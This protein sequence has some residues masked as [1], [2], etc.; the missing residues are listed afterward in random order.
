MWPDLQTT[1]TQWLKDM[2]EAVPGEAV[3]GEA[4]PGEAVPGEAALAHAPD[5][6]VTDVPGDVD[7]EEFF[8]PGAQREATR[9]VDDSVDTAV[10]AGP[11]IGDA[12]TV[13]AGGDATSTN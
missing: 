5:E 3:P 11:D 13:P 7:V 4:V 6:A 9:V 1:M 12:T 8:S 10:R 2:K